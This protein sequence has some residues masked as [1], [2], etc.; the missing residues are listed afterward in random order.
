MI[1]I[2]I[3]VYNEEK[4]I[5]RQVEIVCAFL[6]Q[7]LTD[8]GNIGLVIA[9][10]GSTDA[11]PLIARALA[12][13]MSKAIPMRCVH[14]NEKGVGRAL[15]AS[16]S[17]SLAD[18]VGY[19]DLDL[20]TDLSHLQPALISLLENKADIVAGSRLAQ[21][22]QVV[23]RS[24]LRT[25]VSRCFNALLKI[26]FR[27]SISDGMCGFKFLRREY[28]DDILRGGAVSDGWFFSAEILLVG[29]NL[30]LRLE[31]QPVTWTDSSD[32]K[33]KIISLSLNYIKQMWVLKKRFLALKTGQ[34]GVD[35]GK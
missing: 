24:L 20:A 7:E 17:T 18:I 13:N 3:P 5:R 2:T 15:K 21:G 32:S 25:F 1:E 28:L 16:W 12:E 11:T 29:E 35:G 6:A 22:A 26:L 27:T 30:G 8:L 31:F 33:V 4:T 34:R 9:D 14:L 10:N 23:G 19:M